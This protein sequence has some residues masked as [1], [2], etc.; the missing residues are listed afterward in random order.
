MNKTRLFGDYYTFQLSKDS[1]DNDIN[2]T[3]KNSDVLNFIVLAPLPVKDIN[4]I[5]HK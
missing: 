5:H 3:V 2:S 1:S 4:S